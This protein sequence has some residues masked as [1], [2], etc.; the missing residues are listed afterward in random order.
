MPILEL[1]RARRAA[2]KTELTTL[3][4]T[5][6]TRSFTVEEDTR[7][8][9][10]VADIQGVDLRIG[11]AEVEERSQAAVATAQPPTSGHE[12]RVTVTREDRTYT[13][14]K[15]LRAAVDGGASYFRDA[16]L[17]QTRNDGD[18]QSRLNRHAKETLIEGEIVTRAGTPLAT[19]TSA[20][21]VVPQYLTDLA[22]LAARLGRPFANAA[23]RL[24]LPEQGMSLIIPR[25]TAGALV[26]IQGGE[27][28]DVGASNEAF[29]NLTVPVV[30]IAGQQDV[31]RQTLERGVPGLDQLVYRDLVG[32]YAQQLDQQTLAGTGSA[33]QM[34]GITNVAQSQNTLISA[35]AA[36]ATGAT[37]YSKVAGAVNSIETAGT[38]VAPAN[39][40]VMHPRRWSWLLTLVDGANRP[41]VTPV[42]QGLQLFNG[43]GSDVAPGAYSGNPQGGSSLVDFSGYTVKGYLQGLPV[44]TD[45]NVPNS[46]GTGFEDQVIVC[47]TAH[48][49]LWEI[50]DGMPK[51]LRF[52]QTLGNQLTIKIVAYDYAAFTSSRY[53]AAAAVIG[54]NVAAN[55]S[56]LTAPTF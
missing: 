9:T 37:F 34:I 22:A 39:L 10:L 6:A 15:S 11:V 26:G 55:G 24:E 38:V 7:W 54:G 16:F 29:A 41:L 50:G 1:L 45:A 52:E 8:S 40:I 3:T 30:T 33:G 4:E 18:A 35:F 27:N 46:V 25:G 20:G 2:L 5:N 31:S 56:G 17:A 44:I 12:S 14:R 23:T 36:A 42:T 43:Y 19:G 13:K 53:I 21:L 48:M 51:Q 28:V 32:A 47:N 49:L